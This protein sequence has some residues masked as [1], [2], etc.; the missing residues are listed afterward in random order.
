MANN[1]YLSFS[2]KQI[3][4]VTLTSNVGPNYNM[5]IFFFFKFT[6]T[7]HYLLNQSLTSVSSHVWQIWQTPLGLLL[8]AAIW[9]HKNTKTQNHHSF[10]NITSSKLD[11]IKKLSFAKGSAFN[12]KK[13]L[14]WKGLV[15]DCLTLTFRNLVQGH[16]AHFTQGH[17]MVKAWTGLYIWE[18]RKC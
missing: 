12:K 2:L 9:K 14:G 6:T 13:P 5:V 1:F 17:S 4:Q 15:K 3:F 8:I 18:R 11:L 7:L 16:C 10:K